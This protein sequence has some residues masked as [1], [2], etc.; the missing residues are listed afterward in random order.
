MHINYEK[1][2]PYTEVDIQYNSD[3]PSYKVKKMAFVKKDPTVIQYNKDIII[4]NIPLKA[5]EYNINGRSAI[6]WIID[7][8][9][10]KTDNDSGIIDDSNL[11]SDDEKYIFNLLLKIINLS[12]QT[13][14]LMNSLP[15]LEIEE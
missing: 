9:Q 3:S 8:Y 4:S 6:E 12:V 15:P 5:H 14:D 1:I 2:E 11:Y 13:I 7:Q 10:E